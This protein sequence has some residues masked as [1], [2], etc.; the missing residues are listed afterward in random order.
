MLV[1]MSPCSWPQSAKLLTASHQTLLIL[2]VWI[3]QHKWA[4]L[5]IFQNE[6]VDMA[7]AVILHKLK[8]EFSLLK[9][10]VQFTQ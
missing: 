5:F 10:M 6:Q 9:D 7:L 3:A 8:Y 2:G 1:F 4:T